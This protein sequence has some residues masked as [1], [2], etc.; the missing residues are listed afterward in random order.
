L[1]RIVLS[2]KTAD[3][4]SRRSLLFLTL[5]ASFNLVFAVIEMVSFCAAEVQKHPSLSENASGRPYRLFLNTNPP[6][7]A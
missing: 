3:Y 2:I 6:H 4:K 5:G 7:S 1:E